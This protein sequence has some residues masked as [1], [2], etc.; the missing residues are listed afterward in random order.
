MGNQ[1]EVI[2]FFQLFL[3]HIL[4]LVGQF[5]LSVVKYLTRNNLQ[6]SRP[7]LA[8]GWK[9]QPILMVKAQQQNEAAAW[10]YLCRSESRERGCIFSAT[11]L[12]LLFPSFQDSS[13]RNREACIQH[14]ALPQLIPYGKAFKGNPWCLLIQSV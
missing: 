2:F 13:P 4:S 5:L 8:H 3:T 14:G 11:V 9:V 1:V 10:S 12:H 6:G 7:C